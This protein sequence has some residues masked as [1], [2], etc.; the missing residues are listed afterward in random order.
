MTMERFYRKTR[1]MNFIR[2]RDHHSIVQLICLLLVIIPVFASGPARSSGLPAYCSG[3]KVRLFLDSGYIKQ[4]YNL[5]ERL[6]VRIPDYLKHDLES[7]YK[8]LDMSNTRITDNPLLHGAMFADLVIEAS[9]SGV[10]FRTEILAEHRGASY[11]VYS[12]DNT[13]VIPKFLAAIDTAMSLGGADLCFGLSAGNFDDFKL[14]E[15]LTV[16][17]MDV[18]GGSMYVGWNDIRVT[19]TQI[20]DL[21]AG[22]GLGIGDL[23]DLSIRMDDLCIRGDLRADVEAGYYSYYIDSSVDGERPDDGLNLSA[24]VEYGPSLRFYTQF[25]F[26]NV[27]DPDESGSL[28]MGHVAGCSY[29]YAGGRLKADIVVERRYYGRYFNLDYKSGDD[30]YSYR[31][32]SGSIS[33]IGDY[34]YP[35][36]YFLRPFSQWA[37]YTEYEGRDVHTLIF[38]CDGILDLGS[39]LSVLADL[40]FNHLSVSNEDD[41]IYPFYNAGVRWVPVDGVALDITHTNRGM[42][43]DMHYPTLYLLETGTLMVMLSG[44]FE[45]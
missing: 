40:D 7:S 29:S 42:N 6:K 44:A 10:S 25:G 3:W 37:V 33:T 14:G 13:I 27:S 26:R 5:N 34:L 38:R 20:A 41:F 43:L 4:D 8:L 31:D 36:K 18:Q 23:Y 9:N 15:G 16:Y 22:I 19:Y 24:A 21:M 11:G 12:R 30:N 2:M 1:S 32:N 28:R 17:N 39:G 45:F 35:V